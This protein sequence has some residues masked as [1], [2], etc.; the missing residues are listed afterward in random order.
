MELC[1]YADGFLGKGEDFCYGSLLSEPVLRRPREP[2][3]LENFSALGPWQWGEC[4]CGIG[5]GEWGTPRAPSQPTTW[6]AM[7]LVMQLDR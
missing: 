3:S 4:L 5:R 1:K 6:R 7:L 2:P